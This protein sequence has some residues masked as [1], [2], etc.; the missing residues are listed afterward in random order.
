M[1]LKPG[2]RPTPF[3]RLMR[4]WTVQKIAGPGLLAAAAV[5]FALPE[6]LVAIVLGL[7]AVQL[8]AFASDHESKRQEAM[9]AVTNYLLASVT[10]LE[11]H[12]PSPEATFRANVMVVDGDAL[13]IQFA[14]AGYS[15]QEYGLRFRKNEG[16]CGHAWASS[17]TMVAPT[18]DGEHLLPIYTDARATNRP[19]GMTPEQISATCDRKWIISVPIQLDDGDGQQRVAAVFSLDDSVP[20]SEHYQNVIPPAAESIAEGVA[21]R[22]KALDLLPRR[23]RKKK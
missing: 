7:T 4:H 20:P 8:S 19:W 16:T 23:S 3:G 9:Q 12:H 6:Q 1:A 13:R 14:T 11:T 2:L 22:L 17:K 21:E 5:P 10:A 15:E 18:P